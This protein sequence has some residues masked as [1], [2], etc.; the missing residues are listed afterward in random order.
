[1][2]P[3]PHGNAGVELP[4][5]K[6]LYEVVLRE[7]EVGENRFS[8]LLDAGTVGQG[9][10]VRGRR[11]GDRF[12]PSGMKVDKKL[13]DFFVDEKVPRGWRD[14]VPLLVSGGRIAWVV[15]YRVAEWAKA[16][17]GSEG[18]LRVEFVSSQEGQGSLSE[19]G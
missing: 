10:V 18:A 3:P 4:G 1:M 2:P 15:G 9:L 8:A 12:Q 14:R 13:Q 11:P 5:W 16:G 17:A 6:V 19:E 7:Q